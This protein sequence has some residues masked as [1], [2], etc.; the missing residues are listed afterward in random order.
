MIHV[1]AERNNSCE[2]RLIQLCT[3]INEPFMFVKLRSRATYKVKQSSVRPSR[4][5][6]CQC[7]VCEVIG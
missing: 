4:P 3:I 6:E 5:G 1:M 7:D 2:T